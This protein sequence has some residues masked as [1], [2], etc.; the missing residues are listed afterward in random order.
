MGRAE[1]LVPEK[2]HAQWMQELLAGEAPTLK[3]LKELLKVPNESLHLEYKA[4]S[5]DDDPNHP[6]ERAKL[7]PVLRRYVAGFANG[8][9]GVLVC[10]VKERRSEAGKVV[11]YEPDPFTELNRTQIDSVLQQ[12]LVRLHP[13]LPRGAVRH[14]YVKGLPKGQEILV[15]VVERVEDLVPVVEN[16]QTVHYLRIGDCTARAP[17]YLSEDLVLG[18]RRRPR[19]KLEARI[20]PNENS[21]LV[22]LWVRFVNVGLPW[23]TSPVVGLVHQHQ[24]S[25]NAWPIPEEVFSSVVRQYEEFDHPLARRIFP[26]APRYGTVLETRRVVGANGDTRFGLYDQA[27][28]CF[29][30]KLVWEYGRFW[31]AGAFYVVCEGGPAEW[32][33]ALFAYPCPFWYGG[34][35]PKNYAF[36]LREYNRTHVHAVRCEGGV[37]PRI[38]GAGLDEGAGDAPLFGAKDK[39]YFTFKDGVVTLT[40]ED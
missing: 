35:R 13:Y 33:Q 38:G 10:G 34:E 3:R 9:G 30:L 25:P 17:A 24:K 36:E 29:D 4:T 18:R 37:R 2:A 32:Y 20:E 39:P 22:K 8:A 15:V 31:W 6:G 16:Q 27:E 1:K 40:A 23:A 7:E 21:N 5:V 19:V 26:D 12:A 28:V 11:G 14:A